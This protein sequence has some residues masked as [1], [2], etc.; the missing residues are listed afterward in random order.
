MKVSHRFFFVE[1]PVSNEVI[2]QLSVYKK[3]HYNDNR[4]SL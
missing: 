1:Q 2:V 4:F 3:D